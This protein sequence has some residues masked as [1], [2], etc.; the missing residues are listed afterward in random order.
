MSKLILALLLFASA[1]A[2]E[3]ATLAEALQSE[4]QSIG[5]QLRSIFDIGRVLPGLFHTRHG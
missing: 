1:V 2:Y 5:G 4:M 3:Q